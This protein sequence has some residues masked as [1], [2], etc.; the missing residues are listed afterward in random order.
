M[1]AIV[2][3]VVP[4]IVAWR[5]CCEARRGGPVVVAMPTS[6]LSSQPLGDNCIA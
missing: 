2:G 4:V 3:A 5:A 1:L 6:V